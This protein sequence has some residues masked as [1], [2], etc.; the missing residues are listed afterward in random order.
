MKKTITKKLLKK[1]YKKGN[2]DMRSVFLL[3][4]LFCLACAVLVPVRVIGVSVAAA[5][6][7]I[8]LGL[9]FKLRRLGDFGNISKMYFRLLSLTEKT[10]RAMDSMEGNGNV[11]AYVFLLRF[12]DAGMVEVRGEEYKKAAVGRP[13]YVAFF[14]ENDRPFACFDAAEYDPAPELDL[15]REES[16]SETA[17]T[18]QTKPEHCQKWARCLCLAVLIVAVAAVVVYYAAVWL[19]VEGVAAMP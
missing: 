11:Y 19:L 17:M 15:R 10:E 12:G 6:M 3:V 4:S 7:A 16:G 1:T 18:A 9:Y 5:V 2:A 13:Y 8:F 14:A